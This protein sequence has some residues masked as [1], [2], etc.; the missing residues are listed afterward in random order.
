MSVVCQW[1]PGLGVTH[2]SLLQANLACPFANHGHRTRSLP[3]VWSVL[4]EPGLTFCCCSGSVI[5]VTSS[6]VGILCLK[7]F[8]YSVCGVCFSQHASL[9]YCMMPNF[10]MLS[11]LMW[12]KRFPEW[13]K[14]LLHW[15]V[16]YGTRYAD[17]DWLMTFDRT[18][19]DSRNSSL[20]M[21]GQW[22]ADINPNQLLHGYTE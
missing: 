6:F 7:T 21:L 4:L 14:T 15:K 9:A 10:K 11:L 12:L 17:I 16:Q 13:S 22:S 3:T 18:G 5:R 1:K 2:R 8:T 20:I 19:S